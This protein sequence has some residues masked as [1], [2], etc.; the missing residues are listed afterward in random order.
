MA[1]TFKARMKR[2]RLRAGLKSQQDA[3]EAIGCERGTVGMWEAPSSPVDSVSGE[4]LMQVAA[5]YKVRPEYINTGVGEDG[6][7]W[8]VESAPLRHSHPVRL[9]PEIVQRV[10]NALAKR[11][12]KAG[13]YNLVDHVDEFIRAYE[14]WTG[15]PDAYTSPDI[16]DLVISHA[17]LSPQGAI[18][19][20]R[21]S[22]GVPATGSPRKGVR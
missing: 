19:D 4:Y 22:E 12:K 5:A 18:E 6:F 15:M 9:D 17:D 16:F 2:L 11:H 13:G 10:A 8:D 3:A 7:P 1:E 14:L 21:R 20:E